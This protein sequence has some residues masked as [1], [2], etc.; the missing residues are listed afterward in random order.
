MAFVKRANVVLE[1]KD[2][3]IQMYMSKGYS[4]I[5]ENGN[6]LKECMPTDIN[7][8]QLAYIADKKTIASLQE[9]IKELTAQLKASKKS[10]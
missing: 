2:E 1:V 4:V 9:Q 3:D 6:M 10:K 5:D 7:A 8:L